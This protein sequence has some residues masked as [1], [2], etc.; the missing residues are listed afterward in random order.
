MTIKPGK[1]NPLKPDIELF[2]YQS[3]KRYGLKLDGQGAL[4]VGTI[5]QDDTVHVRSAGKRVG[6]FDEQ[7]DWRGGRGVEDLS[8][9]PSAFWDS[10]YAWT[11]TPGHVH[12]TLQWRHARGLYLSDLHMPSKTRSLTWRA[13]IPSGGSAAYV[14]MYFTS[15]GFA[16]TQIRLWI[17]RVG[18]PGTL[19]VTLRDNT[20]L[21]ANIL[22]TQTIAYTDVVDLTSELKKFA[23]SYTTINGNYFIVVAG[24][25]TDNKTNHWEV[26][27]N[28]E[29]SAGLGFE[30][31][32]GANW[33]NTAFNLYYHMQAAQV[34]RTFFTFFLDEAM[35]VVS[36]ND[37]GSA[38][39]L[40]INGDRGK[41][42]SG[43]S[44]SLSN[45]GKVWSTDMWATA[46]VNIVR[47]TGAGQTRTISA[48]SATKLDVTPVFDITP[49][50]TSEYVI[51]STDEFTEV[52]STGLG[53]V[54]AQPIVVNQIVYFPQGILSGD[55]VI[56]RMV[57][58]GTAHAFSDDTANKANALLKTQDG[59]GIRIWRAG[60]QLSYA[61]AVAWANPPTALTF[62]S[63]AY[64]GDTTQAVTNLVEKDGLV[65]IF[66]EDG[67]WTLPSSSTSFT[68]T[69]LT[70]GIEK[71]P[72]RDNGR[73]VIVHQQ[74]IYYSWLHSMIRMY[75]SSH[76]DVG[77]DFSGKGLPD[78]R[79]GVISSMDSYLSS[80]FCAIDA[81]TG[82]SSVLIYDGLGWHESFRAFDSSLRCRMVKIQPCQETR[83]RI[84]TELGGDLFVQ[85]LP[86]HKSSPRLDSGVRYHHEGVVES[87]AID[88]GTASALPK[89]IKELTVY[90]ENLGDGNEIAVDYQ[91]DDDVHTTNWTH[92]TTLYESPES[93]AFLGLSNIRKFAYRLRIMSSN[94]TVPVD[95]MGVIPNGYARSPYKMVWTLRC[96]A[97]NIIS[98]GRLVKSDTLMRWLLDNARYPGRLEMQSQY[99]LAH[100][101]F[102]IVHPP[103]MFPYK[104]AQN[105]QPEEAVFTIVLEEA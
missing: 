71:T 80:L 91:V 7:R 33:S 75:G 23:I 63:S 36:K 4:Q 10:R 60:T 77:Q 35:Y 97:D 103:R 54:Y 93:S 39:R 50:S 41:A 100:K 13:L 8:S 65:Y 46:R 27:G 11:M 68:T 64:V 57:W 79:E 3:K 70:S 15:Y 28:A 49:D 17:R 76:D 21:P 85:E 62:G 20:A 48:N 72:S 30:S 89:F 34:Q 102:V 95:V 55:P 37:D 51:Y 53:R 19:T 90:C 59:S 44:L 45:S 87:S 86:L 12:Q 81:G 25:A 98:R 96:R 1:Y 88:M 56:R 6:D 82:T 73:A 38:S 67:I 47:G 104:P 84:W 2:D 61:T 94:N 5:S 26:G 92:A 66:K 14:G 31:F 105:G 16:A 99:E 101:F 24:A 42:T 69:R 18:N 83:N 40:W 78:N 22:A 29:G 43:T 58:S 9:N 32:G 52:T 74:F